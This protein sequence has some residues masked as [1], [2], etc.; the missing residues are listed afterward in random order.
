[1]G[2]NFKDLSEYNNLIQCAYRLDVAL[3][4]MNDEMHLLISVH[5]TTLVEFYPIVDLLT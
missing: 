1:M 3:K 4:R 5:L 2:H